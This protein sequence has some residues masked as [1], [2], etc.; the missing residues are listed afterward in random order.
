MPGAERY[1]HPVILA[2]RETARRSP[3]HARFALFRGAL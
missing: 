2:R 3:F 1:N